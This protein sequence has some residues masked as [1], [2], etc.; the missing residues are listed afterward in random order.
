[1]ST[2]QECLPP[3]TI[4]GIRITPNLI[5]SLNALRDE[6]GPDGLHCI[7]E[8]SLFITSLATRCNDIEQVDSDFWSML[9]NLYKLLKELH[10]QEGGAQ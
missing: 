7:A 1:M 5:E 10:S 4:G 9:Y 3:V 8:N 2:Q 6:Y